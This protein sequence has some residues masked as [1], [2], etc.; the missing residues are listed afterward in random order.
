M[1]R[2]AAKAAKTA[3]VVVAN[4]ARAVARLVATREAIGAAKIT[5]PTASKKP[6]TG[7]ERDPASA[8]LVHLPSFDREMQVGQKG[9]S[10]GGLCRA[11]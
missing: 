6:G 3:R 1:A 7:T 4:A 2:A 11:T 8:L 5:T 9:M 10:A